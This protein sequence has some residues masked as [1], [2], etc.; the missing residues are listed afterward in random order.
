V[1]HQITIAKQVAVSE[2]VKGTYR[3]DFNNP[4]RYPF[5]SRPNNSVNFRDPQTLGKITA[6]QGSFSG[7]GRL[8][9]MLP[10]GEVAFDDYDECIE[11]CLRGSLGLS[12][13]LKTFSHRPEL[14]AHRPE[15]VGDHLEPRLGG[16]N[17]LLDDPRQFD[18]VLLHGGDI[19]R[20]R[21]SARGKLGLVLRQKLDVALNPFKSFSFFRRHDFSA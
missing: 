14:I 2:R 16:E 9:L 19:L 17:V 6:T 8:A 5:F 4:F 7:L 21:G 10:V 3:V 11:T 18:Q 12:Q 13:G 20:Q 1:W 15:L